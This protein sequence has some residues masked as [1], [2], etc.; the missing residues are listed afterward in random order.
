MTISEPD[1]LRI[2]DVGWPCLEALLNPAGLSISQVDEGCAIP[3]SHW[4]DEEAGLIQHALYA[5][6]DT[7][8]HSVL[9]EAGHWLLMSEAR[10]AALHTDAKGSAVEEMAVCYLQI[11]MGD[12]VPDM[13]WQRMCQDMDRWGYSFRLGNT[14]AWLQDDA[15]DALDYLAQKLSHTHGIPGLQIRAPGGGVLQQDDDGGTH[16]ETTHLGTTS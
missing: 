9:H 10:R 12:L 4:G 7:P 8:V 13:G 11:L 14:R 2:R 15:D 1:V 6:L 16:V 3:G 5:R